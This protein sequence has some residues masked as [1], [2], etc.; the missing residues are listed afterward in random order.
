ML[1]AQPGNDGRER[2]DRLKKKGPRARHWL[3]RWPG[4][5]ELHDSASPYHGA[6]VMSPI[7]LTDDQLSTVMCAAGVLN[8]ADRDAFLRSVAH[9]RSKPRLISTPRACRDHGADRLADGV[10][11]G[12]IGLEQPA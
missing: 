2:D 5:E 3:R 8:V 7:R 11:V 1:P 6:S 10:P 4:V 12:G 9:H